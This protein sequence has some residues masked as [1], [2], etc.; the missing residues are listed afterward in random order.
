MRKG[1]IPKKYE[2]LFKLAQNIGNQI[3]SSLNR[4]M[5]YEAKLE[6]LE[7][8]IG[9]GPVADGLLFTVNEQDIKMVVTFNDAELN[10]EIWCGFCIGHE[11]AHLVFVRFDILGDYS[12]SDSSF[13]Y[14]NVQRKVNDVYYGMALEELLADYIAIDA[15]AKISKTKKDVVI[16]HLIE[17]SDGRVKEKNIEIV[18]KIISMFSQAN[19]EVDD[20]YDDFLHTDKMLA[21]KNQLLYEAVH[22]TDMGSL[23]MEYD[24]YMGNGSWKRLNTLLDKVFFDNS[25]D[26]LSKLEAEVNLFYLRES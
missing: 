21:P 19:L 20:C 5:V 24:R 13:A 4:K 10:D 9:Q 1:S 23:I 16:K 8:C 17:C 26:D 7:V 18:E 15:I 11:L 6:R 25:E 2:R 3:C 12:E 14:T 22:G